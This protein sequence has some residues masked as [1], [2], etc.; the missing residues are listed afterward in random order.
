MSSQDYIIR[1]IR[2]AIHVLARMTGLIDD[3][4][5]KE[6]LALA[7]ET[8]LDLTGLTPEL[9]WTADRALLSYLTGLSQN[10]DQQ[11]VVAKLFFDKARIHK[12]LGD[13]VASQRFF[14]LSE[15]LLA[16][17]QAKPNDTAVQTLFNQLRDDLQTFET[18]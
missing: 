9:L 16:G 4:K 12:I 5:F 13:P 18:S 1:L 15:Q 6:A 2:R 14:E 8:L 17:M 11:V 3:Q 7:E 10:P